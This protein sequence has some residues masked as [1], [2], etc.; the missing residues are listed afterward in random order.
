MGP[1]AGWDA[2]LYG[3][4]GGQRVGNLTHSEGGEGH[5]KRTQIG[6]IE[7]GPMH[8]TEGWRQR[9]NLR[10]EAEVTASVVHCLTDG[11]PN[12]TTKFEG[13]KWH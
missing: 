1:K 5:C 11:G 8:G 9:G 12:I 3:L 4:G 2:P 7:L 13:K 10:V 6:A